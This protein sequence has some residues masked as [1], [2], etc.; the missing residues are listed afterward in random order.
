[1]KRVTAI[2]LALV[3]LVG[4]LAV[5]VMASDIDIEHILGLSTAS[6]QPEMT[7]DAAVEAD[8]AALTG[9]MGSMAE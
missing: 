6:E 4:V 9:A 2:V 5:G 7:A 8:F 1:M 3:L